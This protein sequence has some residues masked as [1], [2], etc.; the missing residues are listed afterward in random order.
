MALNK[1]PLDISFAQGLDQK[2]DPFRVQAGKFLS[3]TN[4]VF[5]KGG[6]LT[7]R[8]GFKPVTTIPNVST[9]T[10]FNTNLV[11]IGQNLQAYS[12]DSGT[13]VN[14]GK[15]QPMTLSVTPIV[16]SATSQTTVDVAISQNGLACVTWL[17]QNGNSYY[18]VV[19]SNTGAVI[20]PSVQ[21][22]S[23][24]T[25]SRVFS[26]GDYFIVT[27]LATVSGSPALQYVAVPMFNP[28]SPG[29][30]T[31]ITAT[32]PNISAAYDGWVGNDVLYLAWDRAATIGV[33]FM[34]PSL[35]VSTPL[36]ISGNTA[37]LISV[38]VDT[39]TTNVVVYVTWWNSGSSSVFTTAYNANL[40]SIPLLGV[41]TVDTSVTVNELATSAVGGVLGTLTVFYEIA[42]TYTYT[43]NTKTDYIKLNTVTFSGTVGTPKIILRGVGLA[44]KAQY[45]ASTMSTYVIA[46][47]GQQYQ[48]TYFL[49]DQSGNV[50]AK[51]AY[52]NGS[53]YEINQILPQLIINGNTLS[54]GYLF[55][56]LIAPV[57]TQGVVNPAGLTPSPLGVYSQTGIN[58]VNFE[59]GTTVNT[60]EM[61]QN[62][63]ISG[64][65]MWAYDGKQVT[66]QLF[67]VW[68]EDITAVW[69]DSGGSMAA[70]PDGMTNTDAYYYQVTYEWT[71]AQGNI[72]RS[73]P[74]VPV[75]VTTTDSGSSGSVTLNIP[76]LRQTYKT[77]NK[78][79]I[80]IY[81]WSVGQQTYYQVTS[82]TN[83]LLNDPTVDSVTYVDTQ[84][85]SSIIGNLIIYTNGGVIE[86]IAPPACTALTLFD[87]RLWLVDAEDRNLLWFSKQLIEAV[88]VEMSDLLTVFIAPTIGAS[89]STG[90]IF[91]IQ[92]M[93]DKLVI[94]KKDAMYYINGTGPDNTG[95]NNQYSEPIFITS[96]VGSVNP[97][98]L[99]LMPNGIM[100]QSDKGIWLLGRDLSTNYIGAPVENFNTANVTSAQAIPAT[101]QVRFTLDNNY[102]LMYDYYFQQW[103]SFYLINAVSSTL[104]NSLHTYVTPQG[105]VLQETP[106]QYLDNTTAVLMSFT[107]AW[108]NLAGVQGFE[109]FYFANL[110]GTY[111]TPFTL[112]VQ[113]AYNYNSSPTQAIQ[114]TPTNYTG[115]WGSEAL[116]GS[117]AAWGADSDPTDEETA[118]IFSARL[119]PTTQKC[120]SFQLTVNEVYDASFGVTAGQGLS[121]SGLALILGMKK[122]YR[123]QSAKRSY[124]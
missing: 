49:I 59:L 85:D 36:S 26:L 108:I 44:S 54:C 114:V 90:P 9:I 48:P 88:P 55:R 104:Y 31:T 102:A 47:Y 61:G 6:L 23:T 30:A 43:P 32:V 17:D 78:V 74:S 80:V 35:A 50:V 70:Q 51:L 113:F 52:S 119:F 3:L 21:L 69:S 76:T 42:N 87:D 20:V 15:I 112:N 45:V 11:G 60:A 92:P 68:P 91:A 106:G 98:S 122:G 96:V 77:T 14:A 58:L 46:T 75:P 57:N 62:L 7:K 82:V 8:N 103:S 73:A 66:E 89:G 1:Q 117:G 100:F 86:N 109:R 94:F 115:D 13:L 63:N 24:A 124:G 95:A 18:Q 65:I 79:R 53:G 123:T 67:H 120:Q 105:L 4:S 27:Y 83:P 56:D 5:T 64:G 99:V 25:M 16:R 101:N 38:T 107:T 29:P 40:D 12:P 110:L 71:D 10:T 2:T 111:Y 34:L 84:S 37:N 72:Q 39:S 81:R 22:R 93:D 28:S 121:L 118:N 116:W 19:D 33:A 41:T 97:Q